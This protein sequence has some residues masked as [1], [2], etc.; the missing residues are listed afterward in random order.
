MF[1]IPLQRSDLAVRTKLTN[2]LRPWLILAMVCIGFSISPSFRSIFWTMDYLPNIPQQAATTVVLAVGMTFVILTGGIDLSVGSVLALC[3]ITLGMAVKTGIPPFI[4]YLVSFPIGVTGAMMIPISNLSTQKTLAVRSVICLAV[5]Y[6]IGQ[7]VLRGIANGTR[8]EG[9]LLICLL[10]GISCGLI[11]GLAITIGKVP[12]F[13]ATLGM[14]TAAR[15]LTVFATDGNSISGLPLRLQF[16]GTGWTLILCSLIVV[17]GGAIVLSK[18]SIG[19]YI[20]SIGGN[21]DAAHLSGVDVSFVKTLAYT[22]SGFTAAIAA[23]LVTAK[24]MV[25]DTGAGSGGELSA[26]AAVV[27][28]GTSLAGGKGG[29]VGS[30]VGALTISVLTAG[31]V[32][33]GTKDTLQGVVIG[34]V[35]VLTVMVDRIRK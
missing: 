28:G 33:T 18:T 21:E 15:G 24:F 11:N 29:V 8:L 12:P 30:L 10:T 13:I 16:F 35:I 7:L 26:I 25:A 3:C 22:I 6:I 20:Y 4:G 17:A 31:L 23:I 14:L 9:A 27:I 34:M 32:L 1:P 5:T 19:R 2:I